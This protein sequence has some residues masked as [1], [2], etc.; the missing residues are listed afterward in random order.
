MSLST[1]KRITSRIYD[2]GQTRVRIMD[3]KK[4]EEALSAD[5]VRELVKSG[6][7]LILPV[8][9]VGRGKSKKNDASKHAGRGRGVGSKKGTPNATVTRKRR[10][11]I[12]VRALRKYLRSMRHLLD[13]KSYLKAYRMVKGNAFATKKQ[14]RAFLSTN[15]PSTKKVN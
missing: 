8:K 15:L 9:G 7:I 14:L 2:C 6:G 5:D 4:A 3:A 11:I 1:V 13:S 10:W 12:K